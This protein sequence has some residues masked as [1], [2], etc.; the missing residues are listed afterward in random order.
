VTSE[1]FKKHVK[2]VCK[3]R[4]VKTSFPYTNHVIDEGIECSGWFGGDHDDEPANLAVAWRDRTKR[5]Y[6]L[7]HE[8]SHCDQ[9]FEEDP[10]FNTNDIFWDWIAGQRY[11]KD[12]VNKS[13]EDYMKVEWDAERR[14]IDKIKEF[15]LPLDIDRYT[16]R[17]NSYVYFHRLIQRNRMWCVAGYGPYDTQIVL[18]EMPKT[19]DK[20]F[21]N[22]NENVLDFMDTHLKFNKL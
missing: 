22:V 13:I 18:D 12:E 8:F 14:A 2:S 16:Q 6:I 20:D 15:D 4:K 21:L 11:S 10:L 5:L 3:D 1:E 9:W 7:V 19:L 17:A